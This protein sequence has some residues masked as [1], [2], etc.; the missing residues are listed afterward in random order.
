MHAKQSYTAEQACLAPDADEA[1]HLQPLGVGPPLT[2]L[3]GRLLWVQM[4]IE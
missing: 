3:A 4:V 1:A 2:A